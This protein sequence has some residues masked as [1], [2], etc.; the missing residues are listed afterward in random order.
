MKVPR[1]AKAAARQSTLQRRGWNDG[2]ATVRDDIAE[3][4]IMPATS[5]AGV[6]VR[7][8]SIRFIMLAATRA[9]CTLEWVLSV[10][11]DRPSYKRARLPAAWASLGT[12]SWAMHVGSLAVG[13]GVG[14]RW[15]GAH[16]QF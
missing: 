16:R 6:A 3:D 7:G 15:G 5:G 10:C 14:R 8:T 13:I 2:V 9:T 1:K 4:G 12:M 11:A